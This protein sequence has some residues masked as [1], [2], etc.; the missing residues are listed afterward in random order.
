[1]NDNVTKM[2]I[3][4]IT[5][6]QLKKHPAEYVEELRAVRRGAKKKARSGNPAIR[7]QAEQV[8]DE[9]PGMIRTVYLRE[10]SGAK[11]G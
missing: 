7:A 5:K 9:V 4:P 8:L 6:R 3:N 1:M 2:V 11:L 10:A